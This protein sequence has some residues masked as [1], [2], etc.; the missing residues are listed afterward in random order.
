MSDTPET[1]RFLE[2]DRYNVNKYWVKYSAYKRMVEHAERLERERDEARLANG[3]RV[4]PTSSP[5]G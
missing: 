4:K 3:Q 2:C 5:N 1:H